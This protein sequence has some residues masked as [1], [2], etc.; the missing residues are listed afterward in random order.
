MDRQE[1][2][3]RVYKVNETLHDLGYTWNEITQFWKDCIKEAVKNEVL[4]LHIEGL[5]DKTISDKIKVPK[6]TVGVITSKYWSNKM[7]Q[8][9]N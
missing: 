5:S 2:F 9:N 3:F 1:A 7:K 6:T 4:K 8:K